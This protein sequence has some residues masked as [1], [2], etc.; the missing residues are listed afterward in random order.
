MAMRTQSFH[1]KTMIW[2]ILNKRDVTPLL[3]FICMASSCTNK[4][5]DLELTGTVE[6]IG[7]TSFQY[8]SHK[9]M[10][11]DSLF[12]IKSNNVDL[13]KYEFKTVNIQGI[14]IKGY[15]IENGPVLI[16]VQS[17]QLADDN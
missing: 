16:E 1:T 7:I 13:M 10:T 8:G 14:L 4:I 17:I 15:P 9:L 2:K 5:Y 12:A 11:E 3:F 6:P